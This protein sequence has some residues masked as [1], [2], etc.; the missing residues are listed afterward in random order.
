[1]KTPLALIVR[2]ELI[3]FL[4][5]KDFVA[6]L[7][8]VCI[9]FIFALNMRGEGYTGAENQSAVFW[10]TTQ[11]LT[12]TSLFI[13]PIIMA[14]IGTQTVSYTHLDVYKRQVQDLERQQK[15]RKRSAK[16]KK[17]P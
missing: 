15:F 12:V 5:R 13:G 7:G 8:I 14:F 1:M 17:M 10:V 9:G 2:I 11:L 6:I 3:K 16:E 4:K